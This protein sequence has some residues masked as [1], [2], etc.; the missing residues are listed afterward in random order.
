MGQGRSSEANRSKTVGTRLIE[1][2]FVFCFRGF[3][4]LLFLEAQIPSL[5]RQSQLRIETKMKMAV[6]LPENAPFHLI[7]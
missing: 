4:L 2:E 1:N 6:G 7:N 3:S 5:K